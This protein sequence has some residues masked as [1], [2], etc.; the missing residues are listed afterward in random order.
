V[1]IPEALS[2]CETHRLPNPRDRAAKPLARR[3]TGIA[4]L[5]P[6]FICHP[7]AMQGIEY[8]DEHLLIGNPDPITA[9]FRVRAGARA[10]NDRPA[11]R[12]PAL[13]LS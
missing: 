7:G 2:T 10:R 9:G 11:D 8:Q 13:T 12:K 1:N 4:A 3:V 6:S 5:H